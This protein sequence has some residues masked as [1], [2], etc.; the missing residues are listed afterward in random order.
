MDLTET[1]IKSI[2]RRYGNFRDEVNYISLLKNLG[3]EAPADFLDPDKWQDR[4]PQPYRMI[5]GIISRRIFEAAWDII[6]TKLA[7]GSQLDRSNTTGDYV[8]AS[9]SFFPY[10]A[11]MLTSSLEGQNTIGLSKK[12][13]IFLHKSTGDVPLASILRG[14]G[15]ASLPGDVVA[16]SNIVKREKHDQDI[17]LKLNVEIPSYVA[18]ACENDVKTNDDAAAVAVS[19]TPSSPAKSAPA[20]VPATAT[21][22]PPPRHSVH[23]YQLWNSNQASITHCATISMDAGKYINALVISEDQSYLSVTFTD[24]ALQV[25]SLSSIKIPLP[26]A[27]DPNGEFDEIMMRSSIKPVIISDSDECVVRV[28][29]SKYMPSVY[30]CMEKQPSPKKVS[31]FS[32]KSVA[33]IVVRNGLLIFQRYELR[34]VAKSGNTNEPPAAVDSSVKGGAQQVGKGAPPPVGKGG[35]KGAKDPK[36]KTNEE[37]IVTPSATSAD[38]KPSRQWKVHSPIKASQIDSSTALVCTGLLDGSVIIWDIRL[39]VEYAVLQRHLCSVVSM[40]FI[41]QQTLVTADAN[42]RVHIYALPRDSKVG[43]KLVKWCDLGGTVVRLQTFSNNVPLSIVSLVDGSVRV[44]D[45]SAG[46]VVGSL[47]PVVATSTI[48]GKQNSSR[49]LSSKDEDVS[50]APRWTKCPE[51]CIAGETILATNEDAI[52]NG[53]STPPSLLSFLA[54]DYICAM[55]PGIRKSTEKTGSLLVNKARTIVDLLLRTS[56]QQRLD[57]N[58]DLSPLLEMSIPVLGSFAGEASTAAKSV[59]SKPGGIP[60]SKGSVLSRVRLSV[61]KELSPMEQAQFTQQPH[62]PSLVG[63]GGGGPATIGG[64]PGTGSSNSLNAGFGQLTLLPGAPLERSPLIKA[65]PPSFASYYATKHLKSRNERRDERESRSISMMNML[66]ETVTN[67]W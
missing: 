43:R 46:F 29:P 5:D 12:G 13:D 44:L 66:N 7:K 64:V 27:L 40:A 63:T 60:G 50:R 15:P 38:A 19:S 2:L 24:G 6:A 17:A 33:I 8:S 28:G 42:G 1:E 47:I 48:F 65:P 36:K 55:Y 25:L 20:A 11:H 37:D 45:V 3:T 26:L 54:T 23:I 9:S 51:I 34:M 16:V 41:Q 21:T 32:D 59:G 30:F 22:P 53:E 52:N 18:I 10:K 31:E 56:H 49:K 58:C 35:D 62:R 57:P 39:G 14:S 67:K 61:Q 4:L